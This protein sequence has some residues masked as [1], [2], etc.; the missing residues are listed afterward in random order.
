MNQFILAIN[1]GSTSTKIA[2][3]NGNERIFEENIRHSKEE[4][5]PFSAISDQYLYRKSLI[6]E[7]MQLHGI[8]PGS[9]CAVV[10]RGGLLQPM[11]GGVYPIDEALLHDLRVGASGQHACN[12]GGMIARAI[13]DGQ[14]IP[15]FIVD[16]PV[17]D[18]MHDIARLS[19]MPE[20]Q[21]ESRFHTLNQRAVARWAAARLAREYEDCNMVVVH[22]GGGISVTAH[23]KGEAIDTNNG[24]DSEGSYS[25]ERTGTLPVR[26]LINLC[27]SGRYTQAQMWNKTV[28]GGGLL[29]YL[30][31]N[32]AREIERRIEQGDAFAKLVYEGLGY[33]IAKEIGAYATVLKGDVDL[34]CLTGGL[35]RGKSLTD[36]I[37]DMVA[38]I[39]PVMIFP[40][41]D[42]LRAL[43]EGVLRVLDGKEAA[44]RYEEHIVRP[45]FDFS[46]TI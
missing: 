37:A 36:Y 8:A 44:R 17:V 14:G 40:G 20:I 19:G 42:E 9:L 35:A 45:A 34:I 23:R 26:A 33:Q 6:E 31:T 21:R 30:G 25:P 4:L 39:A 2:V 12:L 13:A 10:G 32:D 16:P 43:V 28:G 46:D 11:H 24:V 1:P 15:A 27:Y 22:M 5:L 41:E 18:E 3:Y 38:Y 29:G 7:Q